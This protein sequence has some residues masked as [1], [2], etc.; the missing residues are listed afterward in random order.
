M[1]GLRC[2]RTCRSYS[3]YQALAMHKLVVR[4]I[5]QSRELEVEHDIRKWTFQPFGLDAG[6]VG[7]LHQRRDPAFARGITAVDR[8]QRIAV[9]VDL[10]SQLTVFIPRQAAMSVSGEI[11]R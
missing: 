9:D 5:D 6:F 11:G 7:T 3:S 2:R 8:N 1:P 4:A 10:S